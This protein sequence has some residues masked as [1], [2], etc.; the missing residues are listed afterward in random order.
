MLVSRGSKPSDKEVKLITRPVGC[1]GPPGLFPD[2][3]G[4]VPCFC[5]RASEN[6]CGRGRPQGPSSE[7]TRG[8]CAARDSSY[9]RLSQIPAHAQAL[10]ASTVHRQTAR[11]DRRVTL[12][13][14]TAFSKT[15]TISIPLV[16]NPAIRCNPPRSCIASIPSSGA[17]T[18]FTCGGI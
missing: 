4:E 17:T 9:A 6:S 3:L 13:P 2:S 7:E 1:N 5:N 15:S 8:S 14:E 11:R 16:I 10:F 18:N 12:P